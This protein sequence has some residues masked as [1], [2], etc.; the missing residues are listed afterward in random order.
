MS[1]L[2]WFGVRVPGSLFTEKDRLLALALHEWED[3]L[4]DGCGQPKAESMD[5]AHDAADPAHV[6]KYVVGA[7]W[8]CLACRALHKARK[9][10]AEQHPDAMP[11]YQ[12]GVELVPRHRV[13]VLPT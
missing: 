12:W 8:E 11:A 1:P 7:P 5:P 10:M 13:A 6:A 9:S 4:C 2:A 3:D